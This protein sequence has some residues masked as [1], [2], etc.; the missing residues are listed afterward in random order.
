VESRKPWVTIY[1]E[2]YI[3]TILG[4]EEGL[5]LLKSAID[6]ALENEESK[7]GDM[8]E[9]DF[10]SI[11]LSTE[12]WKDEQEEHEQSSWLEFVLLS[13]FSIWL[14]VLPLF[15]IWTLVKWFLSALYG[16]DL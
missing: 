3:D 6:N 13:F 11:M 8:M 4:N 10:S 16:T 2:R 12:D 7:V 5:K 14:V 9:S 1:D 15:A